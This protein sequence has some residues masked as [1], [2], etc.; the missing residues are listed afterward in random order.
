METS[1][2]NDL[3]RLYA[4][5]ETCLEVACDG[6]RIDAI[7]D[8]ELVEVQHGSLAAIRD[9]VG[10]LLRRH[11]VR[12]VKPI[13]ARKTLVK[14]SRRDGP[15]IGR[16]ASPKSGSLLDLF[17]D[18]VYFTRV[19]PH[20][21]LRLDV[22]LVEI[23]EVRYPGH[24]KRRRRR[25]R[26]FQIQDQR[27]TRLIGTHRFQTAKDLCKTLPRR[28]PRPFHTGHLAQRL[29]ASRDVAQRMA[30]CLRETG[31]LEVAGKQGNAVLYQRPRRAA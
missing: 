8:G 19:Y 25:Q 29:D 31:A 22:L 9:K 15:E 7:C 4:A 13:V 12:V 23:E 1:L 26:D 21:R 20:E 30:Y 17:D 24:G 3:K 10:R 27:L 11:V 18:L 16:R 14:L 5:D 28:L 6:Y 2:H